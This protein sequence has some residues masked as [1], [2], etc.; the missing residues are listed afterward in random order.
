MNKIIQT[1]L[2][3]ILLPLVVVTFTVSAQ[4]KYAQAGMTFLKIGVGAR[5][6]MGGTQLGILG[7]AESMFANPAGLAPLEG[8]EVVSSMTNWIADIKHYGIGAA[9]NFGSLGTFGVSVIYMDNG[10]MI[11]TVPY[12]GFDATLRNQGYENLGTFQIDEY[13]IGISYARQITSQFYIGGQLKYAKQDLGN[14]TIFDQIEG[15]EIDQSNSV[16]NTVLDFGTVYYP[17]WKDF[18][19]GVAV[20]QFAN[21]SD[22]YDARFELP[23]TFDFGV[24]MDLLTVL[25]P[26][27]ESS[28]LTLAL[29]WVH[30]RDYERRQHVGLQYAFQDL[31]FLRGGYKFN[32]DEEGL[33]AGLGVRKDVGGV[34]LKVDYV[35]SDFGIFDSVNRFSVGLFIK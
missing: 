14:V 31:F 6:A 7:D 18:R 10:E 21:Q 26:E 35:Y 9:Y 33:T 3:A 27:T 28:K 15:E 32:Y 19:F 12:D 30:P 13:A 16:S 29:D 34:G 22:Y 20:R 23:L 2:I 17:G 25:L 4:S 8:L 1:L 24:A 5:A 11:R